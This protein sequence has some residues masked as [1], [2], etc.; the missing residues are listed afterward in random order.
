MQPVIR[1][2]D[3]LGITPGGV[4]S[5][6]ETSMREDALVQRV[7]RRAQELRSSWQH[8]SQVMDQDHRSGGSRKSRARFSDDLFGQD[9][10]SFM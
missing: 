5:A 1:R 9:I 3:E 4:L 7:V 2:L 6:S 10:S 8:E